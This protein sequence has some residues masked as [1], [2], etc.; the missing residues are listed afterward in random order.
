MQ[1]ISEKQKFIVNDT[2]IDMDMRVPDF[3]SVENSQG[4]STAES[5]DEKMEKT[6]SE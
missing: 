1:A 3:E 6:A 5:T 2:L 4:K